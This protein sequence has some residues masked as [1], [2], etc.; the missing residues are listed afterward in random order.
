MRL[1]LRML[2]GVA[3]GVCLVAGA[4]VLAGLAWALLTAGVLFLALDRRI[5]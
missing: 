5:P 1:V 4:A 2:P 3:G